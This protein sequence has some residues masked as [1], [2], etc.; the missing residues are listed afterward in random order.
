[1]LDAGHSHEE[2]LLK[3]GGEGGLNEE[4]W[5]TNCQELTLC[6]YKAGT[7]IHCTILTDHC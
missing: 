3:L 1:M 4:W 7:H 5:G 2:E 6:P